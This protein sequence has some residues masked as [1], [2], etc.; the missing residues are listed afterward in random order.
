MLILAAAVRSN[1]S[2][3]E[4]LRKNYRELPAGS[5]TDVD[6]TITQCFSTVGERGWLATLRAKG[7]SFFTRTLRSPKTERIYISS[8]WRGFSHDLSRAPE[9]GSQI[10]RRNV[11]IRRTVPVLHYSSRVCLLPLPIDVTVS[12]K[13]FPISRIVLRFRRR[14]SFLDPLEDSWVGTSCE[15]VR[16]PS[17][18]FEGS[19]FGALGEGARPR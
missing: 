6:I 18:P 19:P 3:L 11:S 12:T 17:V 15:T 2:R 9:R 1:R 10:A 14:I 16:V 7:G 5:R 13:G 4:N 8:I